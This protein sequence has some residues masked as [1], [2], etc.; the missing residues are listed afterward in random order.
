MASDEHLDGVG[1]ADFPQSLPESDRARWAGMTMSQRN[2]ARQRLDAIV[3]WREGR[4]ALADALAASG[5][6][7]TRFY[8]VAAA[9]KDSGDLEALGA[10]AGAGAARQR[11]DPEAV[12]ALQAVVANVVA[13]N[14][15]ASINQLVRAMVDAAGVRE[16]LPGSTRLRAIVEAEIRRAEATGQAGFALKLDF[17][18]I[19]LPRADGRPHIMFALID[20]GTRLV[21]GAST[22]GSLDEW[23]GY[24]AAARNAV[25]R[26]AGPLA[27]LRWTDRL[28]RIDATVGTDRE[29]AAELRERL[30]DGRSHPA[31]NLAPGRFGKYFRKLVGERV[32]RVAIT[33]LRTEAGMAVPDNKDMTPW[34]DEAAAAAVYQAV[35]QHNASILGD[36]DLS[37]GRLALPDD[38]QRA[39]DI[40]RT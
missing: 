30:M 16:N 18:A 38:L 13:M 24:G 26:L 4:M 15:G 9:F 1:D 25:A 2:R 36:L 22:G 37:S 17:T 10:F 29:R 32:G 28:M 23:V 34:T 3:A 6:S 12:N 19:N 27:P 21:L 11:L 40:L 5:L 14:K 8:A 7:R 39:L 35:E 31:V 33:P 20:E